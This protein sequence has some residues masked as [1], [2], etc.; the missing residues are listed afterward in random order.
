MDKKVL[1]GYLLILNYLGVFAMLVGIINLTPL[2]L[3][4]FWPHE[5]EY[6]RFFLWPG[7]SSIL[8]G[9]LIVLLFK[10]YEKGR[11]ER[12]QD[13]VLVVF[14]W[15]L[16]MFIS[17]WPFVLSGQ[18]SFT[19]G[20]F[21]STSGYTTTGMTVTDV[22]NAPHIFLL[23]RSLMQFFGGVGL[24]LVLTS[25]ISDRYGMR[26]YSA[27]GHGDKLMPNLIRSARTILSIYV[28]YIILGTLAYVIFKMPVFDA[29][30][31]A[32]SSVATGGFSTKAAS[33][34]HFN[35]V[36]IEIIT[37]VLMIL[38]GTNFFVHLMLIKG[39]LKPVISHIEV[40]FLGILALIVLPLFVISLMQVNAE[41]FGQ[42]LRIGLF[43][44]VSTITTTGLQIVPSVNLYPTS[45]MFLTIF[46]MMIGAS[47]G[48]T[49]GGMKLYRV[50]L[51]FK[52]VFWNVRDMLGHRK[53]VRTRFVNKVGVR[54][55][56][57][58]EDIT[59]NYAFLM[60]YVIIQVIGIFIF[61]T[62]G[63]SF[64]DSIFE[65]TSILGT[66]GLSVGI[67]SPAAPSL[68]LWTGM[69][70]MLIARLESIVILIAISKIY[71]DIVHRKLI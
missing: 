64:Q 48:S 56:I 33:I 63:Y 31:H 50:A 66:I 44:F 49:A 27:E 62:Q 2:M 24:V 71:L 8:I 6:A 20:M 69:V 58:K 53:T 39:R 35:S 46:L 10:G 70:G 41:T 40:K 47:I 13:A 68:I 59:T 61:T 16:A 25:I 26:L 18:Y 23:F 29:V 12:H 28:G 60:I 30:N 5:A 67:I 55:V 36:P 17:A 43:Q 37:I 34:G 57:E 9:G 15:L 54:S 3:V 21:E 11:L 19:Q 42:A 45:M 32:I 52:S 51:A 4:V 65:F 38:G 22:E 1:S 7:L 14:I